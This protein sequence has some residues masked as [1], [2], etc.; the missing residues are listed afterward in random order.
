MAFVASKIFLSFFSGFGSSEIKVIENPF[1]TNFSSVVCPAWLMEDGS[2]Q[3]WVGSWVEQLALDVVGINWWSWTLKVRPGSFSS[4]CVV[5][6]RVCFCFWTSSLR[7][8][9]DHFFLAVGW[10]AISN[11]L[12][13]ACLQLG[14]LNGPLP[15]SWLFKPWSLFHHPLLMTSLLKS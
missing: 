9:W 10:S 4:W 12:I 15:E 13:P 8:I 3:I 5:A 11:S 7:W 1:H 6:T 14:E 2:A